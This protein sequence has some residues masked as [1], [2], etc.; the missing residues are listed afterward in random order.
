M[1][2][3]IEHWAF[4][5][6]VY[7]FLA[8]TLTV[9]YGSPAPSTTATKVLLLPAVLIS[10]MLLY[11]QI[12]SI[13]SVLQRFRNI[14]RDKWRERLEH[15]I[16]REHEHLIRK[17]L[18]DEGQP[19]GDT[20]RPPTHD[21][22]WFSWFQSSWDYS[23]DL[24]AAAVSRKASKG[25]SHS[26]TRASG[27]EKSSSILDS[28]Y[29]HFVQLLH[30]KLVSGHG[31][32]P[33]ES[34]MRRLK[35]LTDRENAELAISD[36]SFSVFLM[37]IFLVVGAA[38][39]A[40]TESWSF[41]N[42]LYFSYISVL[43]IGLGDLNPTSS[44]GRVIWL[45]YALTAVPIVTSFV[46]QTIASLVHSAAQRMSA[47]QNLKVVRMMREADGLPTGNPPVVSQGTLLSRFHRQV[48][49]EFTRLFAPREF[50]AV[51]GSEP[52]EEARDDAS[53]TAKLAHELEQVESD[54]RLQESAALLG[55][56][57]RLEATGV[58]QEPD[59]RDVQPSANAPSHPPMHDTS[60]P[61]GP[62]AASRTQDP[63]QEKIDKLEWLLCSQHLLL[64]DLLDTTYMLDGL[65][66]NLLLRTLP[67]GS[68]AWTVLRADTVLHG[69]TIKILDHVADQLH[70]ANVPSRESIP[71]EQM[72]EHQSSK[73]KQSLSGPAKS[74]PKDVAS[75]YGP[76]AQTRLDRIRDRMS[77]QA[78]QL[79]AEEEHTS[80]YIQRFREGA[81]R[82]SVFGAELERVTDAKITLLAEERAHRYATL[83]YEDSTV[84]ASKA[85]ETC[86]TEMKVDQQV[87]AKAVLKEQQ[88]LRQNYLDAQRHLRDMRDPALLVQELSLD[89]QGRGDHP[90]LESPRSPSR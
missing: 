8:S 21:S 41:G 36:L 31:E 66:R 71:D 82:V 27:H 12:G 37:A 46:V 62:E 77:M 24:P 13:V 61:S 39:F 72:G 78:D 4:Y 29:G 3:R 18:E 1:F 35:V 30:D 58:A 25:S 51:H 38:I 19:Y 26:N 52:E 88:R 32:Q 68:D 59:T 87:M 67:H 2:S 11:N 54:G 83:H 56:D 80:Q 50:Q 85:D 81:A 86:G 70:E 45:I 7:L 65:V 34:E 53:A 42:S 57:R 73:G 63:A 48:S 76:E 84:K 89:R 47:P 49:N 23:H 17:L 16:E 60:K 9:G 79:K 14:R 15:E 5:D 55:A 40:R 64:D 43:T 69:R 20:R 28:K 74:T 6:G 44:A 10:T 90:E 75:R 22:L 33:M